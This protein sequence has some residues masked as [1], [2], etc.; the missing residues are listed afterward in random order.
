ML[1][2]LFD[3]DSPLGIDLEELGDELTA[4]GGDKLGHDVPT[5][6]DLPV[7]IRDVVVIKGQVAAQEGVE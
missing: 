1:H 6:L 5:G 2:E 7:Q 4:L 3:G